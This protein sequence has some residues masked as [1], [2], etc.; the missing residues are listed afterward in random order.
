MSRKPFEDR[1]K[2][3]RDESEQFRPSWKVLAQYINP[4]RGFFDEQP[5]KGKLTDAKIVIDGIG[6]KS[7]RTMA[8]GMVSGLTSPSRP[9]FRLG[10]EGYEIES[11]EGK[12]WLDDVQ[13]KMMSVFQRSNIYGALH[14]VYEE[15]GTF[16][17]AAVAIL[18]DQTDV[19]RARNFTIGEYYLGCDPAGRVNAF[20]REFWM[21]VGQV[22]QNFGL[23]SCSQSVKGSFAN[24]KLDLWVKVSYCVMPN[25]GRD[26]NMVDFENMPYV[27][28]YWE[29]G[30]NGE[31]LLM[32]EGFEEFPVMAPRWD[33]TTTADVYGKGSPGWDAIG[34]TKMIQQLHKIMLMALEKEA[35][36]PVQKDSS[37]DQINVLPGGV[38][39]Y[40]A[41]T[42]NAGVRP[43]Y[44]V[45]P[46]TQ[47][48]K[49]VINETRQDIG[50]WFYAD[51]FMM[52]VS[53]DRSNVT[54]REIV[55]RHEEKMLM[56]G[57]VIDRLQKELLNPLIER[58]FAIMLRNGLIPPPPA[59][60]QGI[61]LKV[62]Y[63]S[64]L[65][66][67]QKMV[68][69]AVIEQV[70][71]FAGN[72]AAGNKDVLDNID[73]DV[74]LNKYSNMLG[75]PSEIIRSKVTVDAI[76]KGRAEAIAQAQ[77]Q[78]NALAA[79][80]GAKVMSDTPIGT[81][82]ALDTLMAGAGASR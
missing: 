28:C 33:L 1:L 74:T 80:Q 82:S 25:D 49:S 79:V 35:N 5:N 67:A 41:Q 4:S 22:V 66:Q 55:E 2:G 19:I 12:K 45:N 81:G 51:L 48:V 34:D 23:E 7:A 17:T 46:N 37:V 52:M 78:A 42:P 71:A 69:T 13:T 44:Q 54:A 16:A 8:S 60:L 29:T 10:V 68:W 38:S 18:E 14:S 9:W 59:E 65:A 76:R 70:V 47:A 11:D 15:C 26:E 21:T 73:F 57:P 77:A 56:L 53:M 31:E 24:K 27:G 61:E 64:M 58:T 75:I 43:V 3:M 32:R 39:T 72:L 40:S 62:E 63:I 30:S 36:P 50:Q 6:R 20:G